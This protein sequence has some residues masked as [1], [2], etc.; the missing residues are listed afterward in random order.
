[1]INIKGYSSKEM[2]TASSTHHALGN[3]LAQHKK[4]LKTNNNSKTRDKKKQVNQRKNLTSSIA[5][6]IA[7]VIL[8]HTNSD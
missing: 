4:K 1:M 5:K 2:K 3:N 6:M 8:T 7:M